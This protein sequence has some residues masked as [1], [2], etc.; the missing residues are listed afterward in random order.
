MA[1]VRASFARKEIAVKL[2]SSKFLARKSKINR[3]QNKVNLVET[4]ENIT[5]EPTL[6]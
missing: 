4:F 2:P 1:K 6:I 3:S 5:Y